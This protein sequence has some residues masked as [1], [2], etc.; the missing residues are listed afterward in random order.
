MLERAEAQG[1]PV[2]IA[3]TQPRNLDEAGRATQVAMRDST[4]ARFS[5]R[6]LDF[7][8]GLAE[9][10]ATVKPVYDSGDGIHLGDAAHALLFR[11]VAEADVPEAVKADVP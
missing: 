3:T 4:H 6:A 10:D 8:T 1:V 11:R 5:G 2:W 9:A 7:W